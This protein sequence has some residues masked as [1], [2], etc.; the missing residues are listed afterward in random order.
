MGRSGEKTKGAQLFTDFQQLSRIWTH[1][2][3]LQMSAEKAEKTAERK[4]ELINHE[5]L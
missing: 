1:P 4:V 3:V 2:R 5:K